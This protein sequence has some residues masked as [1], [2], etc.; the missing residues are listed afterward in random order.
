MPFPNMLP[1]LSYGSTN[2][3]TMSV[4]CVLSCNA[5][6]ESAFLVRLF[7]YSDVGALLLETELGAVPAAASL[8]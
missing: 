8:W 2:K 3:N 7:G 1:L 5:T 4:Q 6:G